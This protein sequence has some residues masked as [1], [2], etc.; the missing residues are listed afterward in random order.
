MPDTREPF[1]F[2]KYENDD[3]FR[4]RQKENQSF[5]YQKP[6]HLAQQEDPWNRLHATA[7][8]SSAS[9]GI[10][11][12]NPKAPKDSLDIH[13][14][15][16][17]DHSNEF[18]KHKNEVLLQKSTCDPQSGCWLSSNELEPEEVFHRKIMKDRV[19]QDICGCVPEH[20]GTGATYLQ[21]R[22][23]P[24]LWISPT[25][26]SIHSIDGAITSQHTAAT[27]GGYSR[28]IDGGFF[29]I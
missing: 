9:K 6:T 14:S 12:C 16:I 5:Q 7:T 24:R 29:A 25:K 3:D 23:P 21:A 8:V 2:P 13:L 17:Y 4:G 28:K 26:S 19:Q 15:A 22:S 27:N 20:T 18:L 10:Y 11:L 1:P